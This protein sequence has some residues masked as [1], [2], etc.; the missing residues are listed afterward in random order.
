MKIDI[1]LKADI[2]ILEPHEQ[3]ITDWPLIMIN[4]VKRYVFIYMT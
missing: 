3:V 4:N 2:Y 1:C